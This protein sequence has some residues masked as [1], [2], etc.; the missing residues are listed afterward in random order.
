MSLILRVLKPIALYPDLI[1][2]SFIRVTNKAYGYNSA[3]FYESSFGIKA[4]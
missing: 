1:P 2:F 4:L 3:G